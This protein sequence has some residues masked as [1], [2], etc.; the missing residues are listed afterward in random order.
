MN[1]RLN[2][3]E[4][5]ISALDDRI[6][7]IYPIRMADERDFKIKTVTRDKDTT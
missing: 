1:S 7:G 4:K 6:M 5:K 2:N 3:A